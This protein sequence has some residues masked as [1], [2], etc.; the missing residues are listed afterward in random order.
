MFVVLV[1]TEERNSSLCL[2]IILL[3]HVQVINELKELILSERSISLTG[4]LFEEGLQL[5]LKKSRV[6]VEIEVDD[7]LKII[8]TNGGKIVEE[9]LSDLSLTATGVTNQH[10]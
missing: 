9:T 3:G 1:L 8:V 10:R 7:L 5:G 6:S 2:I 4:L